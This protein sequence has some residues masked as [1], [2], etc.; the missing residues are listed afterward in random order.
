VGWFNRE[1]RRAV[2]SRVGSDRCSGVLKPRYANITDLETLDQR[3]SC[4][5]VPPAG[6]RTHER[7]VRRV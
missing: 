1:G 6:G 2:V 7:V 5:E 4:H 3:S